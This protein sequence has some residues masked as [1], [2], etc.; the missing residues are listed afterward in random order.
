MTGGAVADGDLRRLIGRYA[1]A[2]DSRDVS[3]VTGCFAADA[4][5]TFTET[6]ETFIGQRAIRLF[7]EE[8]FTN[9]ANL[10]PPARSTH[11]MGTSDFWIS[12]GEILGRTP[13]TAY[14]AT[15]TM[16]V[17]RGLTYN[18]RF[19]QT[20]N[21]WRIAERRHQCDWEHLSPD[22]T[23]SPQKTPPG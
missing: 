21:G 10:A 14:L 12:D 2:I 5:M 16:L 20:T 13:A 18:D 6:N 22:A 15:S 9:S 1:W 23:S 8:T 4:T 17:V 19:T 3:T 11:L 7:F